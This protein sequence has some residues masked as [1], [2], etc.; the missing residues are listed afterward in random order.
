MRRNW[1][2]P[3]LGAVLLGLGAKL[4]VGIKDSE[5][6]GGS[7]G[8]G[9]TPVPLAF[10]RVKAENLKF[11]ASISYVVRPWLKAGRNERSFSG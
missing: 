4:V 3:L 6:A 7:A 8:H 11:Q 5:T 10:G 2:W 9:R 1:I